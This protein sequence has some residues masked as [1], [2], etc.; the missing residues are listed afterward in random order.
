MVVVRPFFSDLG[1]GR[2]S[3]PAEQTT[4]LDAPTPLEV[5]CTQAHNGSS[6]TVP[7]G[8]TAVAPPKPSAQSLPFPLC[9]CC[10]Y[11]TFALFRM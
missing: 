10:A 11:H 7:V 3:E 4:H 2:M 1:I 5:Q 8:D 9:K 6:A